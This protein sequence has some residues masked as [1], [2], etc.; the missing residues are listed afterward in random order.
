[1][2]NF[3]AAFDPTNDSIAWNTTR[4]SDAAITASSISDATNDAAHTHSDGSASG[5]N[6]VQAQHAN[7]SWPHT[8]GRTASVSSVLI[9]ASIYLYFIQFKG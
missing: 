6:G 3:Y 8:H 2:N 1:M 5:G 7:Q 4:N 9:P